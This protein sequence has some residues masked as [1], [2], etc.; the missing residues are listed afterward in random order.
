MKK[1]LSYLLVLVLVAVSLVGGGECLM[2]QD[3]K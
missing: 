1:L 2:P 3:I